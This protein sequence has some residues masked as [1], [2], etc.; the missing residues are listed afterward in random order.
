MKYAAFTVVFVAALSCA[1]P[2]WAAPQGARLEEVTPHPAQAAGIGLAAALTN[3]VYFPVRLA[4]TIATAEVG[5]ITGFL[6]GGDNVSASAVWNS[7]EGQGFVT[8]AILE[9]RERLRLGP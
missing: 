3:T 2:V 4:M 9:G 8:P 7:T 5:G 6:T 1:L